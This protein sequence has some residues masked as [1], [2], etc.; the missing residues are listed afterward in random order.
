M[1]LNGIHV[2]VSWNVFNLLTHIR[3]VHESRR[4]WIDALCINQA[5]VM[6]REEQISLMSY[7]YSGAARTIIWLG[8]VDEHTANLAEIFR[9]I[10]G[11]KTRQML[12]VRS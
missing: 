2:D 7:I 10:G 4:V 11:R 8:D 5:D 6:E 12:F 1:F 9:A 3:Y